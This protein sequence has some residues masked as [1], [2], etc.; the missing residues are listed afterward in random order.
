[1]EEYRVIDFGQFFFCL[2]LLSISLW[3]WWRL[4]CSLTNACLPSG[5]L[6]YGLALQWAQSDVTTEIGLAGSN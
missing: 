5:Q 1:M 3:Q 2:P 4:R 6:P